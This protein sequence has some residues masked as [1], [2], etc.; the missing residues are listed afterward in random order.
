MDGSNEEIE[1]ELCE[2]EGVGSKVMLVCLTNK[3]G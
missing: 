2:G 1:V 3:Y